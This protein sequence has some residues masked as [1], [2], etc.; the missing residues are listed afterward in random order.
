LGGRVC[1]RQ[2]VHPMRMPR[3]SPAFGLRRF[4]VTNLI[5]LCGL[6]ASVALPAADP[7]ASAWTPELM[8]KAKGVGDLAVSP[9]GRRVAYTISIAVMDGEKSE[10]VS[11]I[12]VSDVNGGNTVQLTRSEKSST[13]PAWSPDGQSI[14]FLS[15][16]AGP[17]ANLWRIAVGGG[18]AEQLTDEKGGLTA[19]QWSPHGTQIAFLLT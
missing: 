4:A 16:R 1:H 18:E 10:W 6:L 5:F 9:D 7:K 8:F 14:A 19:F 3:W 12:Y 2:A 15:P 13:N 11:Q 17:K